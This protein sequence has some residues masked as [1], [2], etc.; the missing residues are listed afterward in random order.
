MRGMCDT[1]F[2]MLEI[3]L[4][5]VLKNVNGRPCSFHCKNP[6]RYFRSRTKA[7]FSKCHLHALLCLAFVFP[8]HSVEGKL[9]QWSAELNKSKTGI[10]FV[11]LNTLMDTDR[12]EISA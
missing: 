5:E 3:L 8:Q 9:A 2:G 4:F 1:F 12:G 6:G 11:K 10:L 7:L